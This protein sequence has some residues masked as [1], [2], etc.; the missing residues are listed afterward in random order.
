MEK[1]GGERKNLNASLG[2]Q[3]VHKLLSINKELSGE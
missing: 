2:G 1:K 3:H